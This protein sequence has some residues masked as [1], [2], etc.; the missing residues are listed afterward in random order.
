MPLLRETQLTFNAISM[1]WHQ[2]LRHILSEPATY[3][4][5][6]MLVIPREWLIYRYTH[7]S[8]VFFIS[9]LLHW[10]AELGGGMPLGASGT[11]RFFVTQILGIIL[12]DAA[13]FLYLSRIQ[14]S[15]KAPTIISL[16]AIGYIWVL[17]FIVWSTPAWLY[18]IALRP[19]D[20]PIVPFSIIGKLLSLQLQ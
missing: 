10:F 19:V 8:F 6:E 1:F 3:L 14:R 13:V 11:V 4:T 9:G 5:Q 12:E 15:R 18:P 2:T 7:L 16:K 20:A 17:M